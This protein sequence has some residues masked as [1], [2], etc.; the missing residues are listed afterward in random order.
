MSFDYPIKGFIQKTTLTVE[1]RLL[2]SATVQRGFRYSAECSSSTN[3]IE[4]GCELSYPRILLDQWS[5]GSESDHLSFT[6]ATCPV[7]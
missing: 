7:L 1:L 6:K 4:S 5:V 3:L 2:V